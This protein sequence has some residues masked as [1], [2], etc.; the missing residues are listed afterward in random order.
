LGDRPIELV[1]ASVTAFFSVPIFR[2]VTISM[3]VSEN[4]VRISYHSE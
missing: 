1:G 3:R 4:M 2:F